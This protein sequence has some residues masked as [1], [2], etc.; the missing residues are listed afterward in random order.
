VVSGLG[1]AIFLHIAGPD[2][3]PTEGC[4]AL[5]IDDLIRVLADCDETTT[6]TIR[7]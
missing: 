5:A 3:A 1:S 7:D 6:I 4:V 2:Y